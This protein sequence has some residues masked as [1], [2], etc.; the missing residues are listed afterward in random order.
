MNQAASAEDCSLPS[1]PGN[2]FPRLD[3]GL[4]HEVPAQDRRTPAY[5]VIDDKPSNEAWGHNSH[6][7]LRNIPGFAPPLKALDTTS[8]HPKA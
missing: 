4:A 5:L 8:M 7:K 2:D 3:L 1:L 6:Q